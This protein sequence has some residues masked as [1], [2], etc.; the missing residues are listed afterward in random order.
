[1]GRNLNKNVFLIVSGNSARVTR[2]TEVLNKN[3]AGCSIFHAADWFETKYKI[4]NIFP[5]IVFVD[6]YLPKVAGKEVITKILREKN[7][8]HIQ[9]IMMSIVADHDLYPAGGRVHFLT[10]PD[11][12]AAILESLAKIIAPKEASNRPEYNLRQ[13][14]AGEVLFKEGEDT[15]AVYIVKNGTLRAYSDTMTGGRI[16]LGDIAAG[17][18]VGEM[19]HFNHEPRSATVEAVTEVELVEIPL[20]SL[21]NVIFSKPSWAKALVKTLSQRLKRA[22]KVLTG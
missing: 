9:V 20:E 14:K 1:M 17:E 10:E 12:E 22:N 13:L 19:G 16:T 6:E 8:S 21:E 4:D 2:I 7:S 11:R 15:Q 5:K 3:Y 18:F